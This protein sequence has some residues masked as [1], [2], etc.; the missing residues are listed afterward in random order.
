MKNAIMNIVKNYP[1]A[2]S[3][4]N[5]LGNNALRAL[6]IFVSIDPKMI[7]FNSYGGKKYDDSP[8]AIY[9]YM[10]KDPRFKDFSFVW[11]FHNPE[12]FEIP[13]GTKIKTDNIHYFITALKSKYWI[14]NSGIGRGLLFKKKEN[15]YIN[16]WHG[17]P[18]K[19]M[20]ADIPG[21]Q[22]NVKYGYDVQCAQGQY[23]IDVFSR[24]FCIPRGNFILSGL[25]RNDLL[26]FCSEEKKKLA[27]QKLGLDLS[28]KTILYAPTFRE[29][30]R[31]SRLN[32]I[33]KPP[34]NLNRWKEELG[35]EF[36]V[37]IRCHYEVN[38]LFANNIDGLFSIDVSNYPELND[39]M[40][41]SDLLIT[42]YSSIMF[43]YSILSR[44]IIIFAYDYDTYEKKRG[45]YFDLSKALPGGKITESELL[46]LIKKE[47]C[48][49]SVDIVNAFRSKYVTEY[50]HGTKKTVE[51]IYQLMNRA[52]C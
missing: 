40:I 1:L 8:R 37:L 41:A 3:V 23:D 35:S 45:M 14:T 33:L 30:E 20:G 7:L 27:K 19:L 52:S 44:P 42:D 22:K 39:L 43:D 6:S 49:E 29:Y 18:L 21:N 31:D 38:R 12:Q 15:V 4:F 10:I 25:P 17:T 26:A 51:K 46:S 36:Q 2:R 16:T 34:I 5:F 32:C 24:A 13:V 50:G 48:S 11:A 28:K 47:P 9:E